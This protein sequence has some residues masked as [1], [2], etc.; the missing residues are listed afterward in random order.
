MMPNIYDK[1]YLLKYM[2]MAK[3]DLST[4]IHTARWD[5]IGKYI[6]C[7]TVLDYGCGPET[8]A[9]AAPPSY[10]VHGY[11]INPHC[12]KTRFPDHR[13][14]TM[15]FWDSLEH[16]P[17]FYGVISKLRPLYIFLVT[18]NLNSVNTGITQWRHYRPIEHLYYF[19]EASL[20]LIFKHLGYTVLET[21]YIE[22]AL[23][24]PSDPEALLTM[25]LKR[26]D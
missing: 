20:T 25:A 4:K 24:N 10:K 2:K 17:D 21:N 26:G 7:G 23:R 1:A 16:T 6:P 11:D 3:T 18:P 14:T 19:D 12:K 15:T 9:K 13:S 22:G 5:L 8:F